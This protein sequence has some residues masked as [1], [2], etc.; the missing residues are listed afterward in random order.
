MHQYVDNLAAMAWQKPSQFLLLAGFLICASALLALQ[1]WMIITPL[2]ATSVTNPLL[3]THGSGEGRLA[4]RLAALGSP[5]IL[6]ARR[7]CSCG[8]H[9][10]ATD[11]IPRPPPHVLH[12]RT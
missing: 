5:G 8:V 7:N 12:R 11:A 4:Q 1:L 9:L 3:L 2:R 6:C 10:Q